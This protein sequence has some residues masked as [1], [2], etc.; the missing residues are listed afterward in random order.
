MD[1]VIKFTFVAEAFISSIMDEKIFYFI[2]E[3]KSD[4]DIPIKNGW[5]SWW[6]P[7]WLGIEIVCIKRERKLASDSERIK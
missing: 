2:A 3:K 6:N 7:F 4:I 5:K 1:C